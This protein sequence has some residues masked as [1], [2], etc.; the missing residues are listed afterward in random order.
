MGLRETYWSGL[1]VVGVA[2]LW[3]FWEGLRGASRPWSGVVFSVG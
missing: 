3:R 2:G 1:G